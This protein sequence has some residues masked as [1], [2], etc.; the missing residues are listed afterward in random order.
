[1]FLVVVISVFSL[2]V[3]RRSGLVSGSER[4]LGDNDEKNRRSGSLQYGKD[5]FWQRCGFEE[6][7]KILYK[8][9]DDEKIFPE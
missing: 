7:V 1:M 9:V 2:Q 8:G 6:S 5:P 3:T 4:K